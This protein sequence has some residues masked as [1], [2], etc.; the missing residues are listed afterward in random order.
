MGCLCGSKPK[1]ISPEHR[2]VWRILLC[3]A[4]LLGRFTEFIRTPLPHLRNAVVGYL[5]LLSNRQLSPDRYSLL[6]F[7]VE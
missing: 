6:Y 3:A 2:V 5:L 1:L 7:P 4:V